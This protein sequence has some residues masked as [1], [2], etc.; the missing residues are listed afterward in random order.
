MRRGL[1]GREGGG[2]GGTEGVTRTYLC[3]GGGPRLTHS[4]IAITPRPMMCLV[5]WLLC[6]CGLLLIMRFGANHTQDAEHWA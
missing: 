6:V 2:R 1:G 3:L 5:L 4:Y